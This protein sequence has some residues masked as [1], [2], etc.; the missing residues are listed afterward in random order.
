VGIAQSFEERLERFVEGFFARTFRSGL[1]PVEL[2]KKLIREMDRGK[3]LTQNGVI[4][5]NH[6]SVTLSPDDLQRFA[7]FSDSLRNE[8]ILGMT[9]HA[10]HEGWRVLGNIT[11]EFHEDPDL[12]IGRYIIESRII[13]GPTSHP[14]G[15]SGR[16]PATAPPVS[17]SQSVSSP[18]P[19]VGLPAAM[20]SPAGPSVP[21]VPSS[22]SNPRL[23]KEDGI[24]FPMKG[25]RVIVGRLPECHVQFDDSNV[26][27]QHAEILFKNGIAT[28][29]DLGSTNGTYVNGSK[30]PGKTTLRENDRISVG[31]HSLVYRA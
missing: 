1:Q 28:V 31:R 10:Q 20:P 24:S 19:P 14:A 7:H 5:A 12:R 29:Q 23:V 18:M 27:R 2:G 22:T 15:T 13:E 26:S 16:T 17:P 30:I 6:Y 11:I 8:L 4:I 21:P 25:G 9:D 3:T